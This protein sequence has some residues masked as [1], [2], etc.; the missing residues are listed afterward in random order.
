[1]NDKQRRIYDLKDEYLNRL[2]EGHD[3]EEFTA[4]DNEV[5]NALDKLFN[6]YRDVTVPPECA[7]LGFVLRSEAPG[8]ISCKTVPCTP[9]CKMPYEMTLVPCAL[10]QTMCGKSPMQ[11]VQDD[12]VEDDE[13]ETNDDLS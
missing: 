11:V 8:L 10:I 9:G 3:K 7:S 2:A 13:Q 6:A 12:K 4:F 1:M 5:L